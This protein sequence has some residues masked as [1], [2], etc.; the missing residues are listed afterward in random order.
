MEA[1]ANITA[2]VKISSNQLNDE[3]KLKN[4]NNHNNKYEIPIMNV[5]NHTR[6]IEMTQFT[7]DNKYH[8]VD[9]YDGELNK[10]SSRS[11]QEDLDD[12]EFL[13]KKYIIEKEKNY[14]LEAEKKKNLFRE[15]QQKKLTKK[16]VS[17]SE[18]QKLR[19]IK[20]VDIFICFF[21]LCD[22]SLSVYTNMRFTSDEYDS[23]DKVYKEKFETDQ[24]IVDLRIC[25]MFIVFLIEI[26]LVIKYHFRLKILRSAL[27]ASMLDNI[28]T[29][30]LYKKLL[31]EMIIMIPFSFP[32]L[33]GYFSGHMLFGKYTYSLDSFIL[34]LK[35]IKLYYI[36]T[37]YKHL[38]LWTSNTA[39]ENAK[40]YKTTIGSNFILKATIKKNP[41]ISILFMMILSISLFSFMIRIFEYGFSTEDEDIELSS[42]KAIKNQKFNYYL[43]VIWVV[44]IS[45]TTVG[46]GDIFPRTHMGRF[47]A[48]ISSIVGMIIQSLLI[49]RLSDLVGLS[50]DEKKAYSEIKKL[51]D[52]NKIEQLS[53]IMIKSIFKLLKVKH[54]Q[55]MSKKEK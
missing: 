23:N 40:N 49:V 38:S 46:Y 3:Y 36:V 18:N 48:F 4:N 2:N 10:T 15:E 16:L 44:I 21:V 29:T 5:N 53:C 20:I 27:F 34:L 25:I 52:Q 45:M 50:I 51:D 9:K 12:L 37:I 17:F 42:S 28:F 24:Q 31:L 11:M 39:Q 32:N 54:D 14:K 13:S 19:H 35:M 30:G 47:V 6:I 43:D 22:I 1:N 7:K 55:E 41:T 33:N 26:L 8:Q